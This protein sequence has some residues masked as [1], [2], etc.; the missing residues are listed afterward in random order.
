MSHEQVEIVRRAIDAYNRR[1]VD[2]FLES[3]TEDYLLFTAVAGAVEVGGIRGREGIRRYFDVLDEAWEEFR[4]IADD[5][6]DLGDRVL[7]IGRTEGR[8]RV[9]GV[10]VDSPYGVVADFRDGK[11]WRDR[12]FL[13]HDEAMRAAGLEE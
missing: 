1:D 4:I 3:T 7:G 6:R 10:P 8:G 5:V 13:D 12:G 11:R 2:G 9:S